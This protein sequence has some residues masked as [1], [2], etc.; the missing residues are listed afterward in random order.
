MD[1][2]DQQNSE[3]GT[4]PKAK[5][6]SIVVKGTVAKDLELHSTPSNKTFVNVLI[7]AHNVN[8]QKIDPEDKTKKWHQATFWNDKADQVMAELAKGSKIQISGQQQLNEYDKD[9]EK[10]FSSEIRNPKYEVLTIEVK[11][12]VA[13]KPELYTNDKGVHIATVLVAADE[14]SKAG[15]KLEAGEHK[16]HNAVFFNDRAKEVVDEL[17]KGMVVNLTGEHQMKSF[18]DKKT[19]EVREASEIIAPKV[20]ILSLTIRG[21][22]TKDLEL[23]VNTNDTP[24]TRISIAADH[25]TRGSQTLDADSNKWH[26]VVCWGDKAKE[27]VET[28]KKGMEVM[29]T[30]EQR[31]SHFQGRENGQAMTTSEIHMPKIEPFQRQRSQAQGIA[32]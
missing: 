1:Q 24:Y 8:G 16:W 7:A 29:V 28:Y 19:G 20:E 2:Q 22:I 21:T 12:T 9:G 11:G 30:G 23:K 6:P 15:K 27:A 13:K 31:I 4:A 14:I 32:R 3:S 26:Q 10:R 18:K 5:L 25:V 17:K